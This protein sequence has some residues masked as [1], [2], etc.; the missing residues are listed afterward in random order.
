MLWRILT[1]KIKGE[2]YFTIDGN[3]LGLGLGKGLRE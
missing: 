3:Y 2:I 1:K